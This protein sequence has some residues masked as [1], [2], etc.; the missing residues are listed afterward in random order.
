MTKFTKNYPTS[1]N[2]LVQADKSAQPRRLHTCFTIVSW[3]HLVHVTPVSMRSREAGKMSPG[4]SVVNS[5]DATKF[6][7]KYSNIREKTFEQW[8]FSAAM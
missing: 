6:A 8:P 3:R 1:V 5:S 7:F 4:C 2:V